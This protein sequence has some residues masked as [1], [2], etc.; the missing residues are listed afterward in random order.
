MC[1]GQ[2]LKQFPFRNYFLVDSCEQFAVSV[3]PFPLSYLLLHFVDCFGLD[4]SLFP[5]RRSCF[6]VFLFQEMFQEVD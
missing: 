1:L 3:N 6:S 2:D 4:R 5:E